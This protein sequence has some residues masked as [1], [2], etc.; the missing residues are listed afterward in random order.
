MA[1]AVVI[2]F[3]MTI[4]LGGHTLYR[5]IYLIPGF[6]SIR[7]VPRVILVLLLPLGALFGLLIDDLVA[8]GSRPVMRCC[9]ALSLCGFLVAE[10]SLVRPYDSAP[11][12]W[13]ARVAALKARLPSRLPEDAILAIAAPPQ[14]QGDLWPWLLPQIDAEIA[15]ATLGINTLNGYSGYSPL[16]WR[17][18]TTCGDVGHNIRAGEHFLAE[19]GLPRP[20]IQPEQIVLVGFGACDNSE[21]G[22][23][24]ALQ[25]GR[26]YRFLQGADGNAFAGDGFAPVESS[27][28]WTNAKNA[29]LFFSLAE[30]PPGPVSL[31]IEASSFS[32]AA[33]RRQQ[34][35]VEANGH[36]CGSVVL[37]DSKQRATVTC[38]AGAI[39]RGNNMLLFRVSHPT[40][41]IDLGLSRD[42]THRGLE[43]R[44]VTLVAHK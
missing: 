28:R 34:A 37:S 40:R 1:V 9:I 15:A 29:F 12:D 21:L 27:G 42:K 41:P 8:P 10:C 18:M 20:D 43:L 24:P 3:A 36:L 6:S 44:T 4:S 33:D 22:R 30:S 2:L 19:H 39:R 31:D 17:T 7:A 11:A 35:I 13:Q 16:T 23:D 38:P 25:L 5:L 32:P 26:T 14:Q